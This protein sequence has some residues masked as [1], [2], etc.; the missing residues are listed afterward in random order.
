M[1]LCSGW[2]SQEGIRKDHKLHRLLAAAFLPNPNDFPLVNHKDG[3]KLNNSLSNLEWRSYSDNLQHAYDFKLRTTSWGKP[4]KRL[5][6][7]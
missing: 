7:L 1:G 4:L 5:S 2:V 3:N 6:Q